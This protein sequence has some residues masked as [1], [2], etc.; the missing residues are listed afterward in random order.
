MRFEY[1][2]NVMPGQQQ[3]SRQLGRTWS[4]THVMPTT[5][6]TAAFSE[7]GRHGTECPMASLSHANADLYWNTPYYA[8]RL[9]PRQLVGLPA[10][11]LDDACPAEL[12]PTA[13][14]TRPFHPLHLVHLRASHIYG[15]DYWPWRSMQAGT[16]GRV[17]QQQRVEP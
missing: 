11:G 17:R 3:A 16:H 7:P 13:S 2:A 5:T 12:A 15:L 8:W 6:C 4:P 9:W 10:R 1:D 14:Q